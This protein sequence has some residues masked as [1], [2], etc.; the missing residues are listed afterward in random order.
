MNTTEARTMSKAEILQELVAARIS[1]GVASDSDPKRAN[2][3][4]MSCTETLGLILENLGLEDTNGLTIANVE[5][6]F[7]P[8]LEGAI[9]LYNTLVN[10]KTIDAEKDPQIYSELIHYLNVLHDNRQ[11]M[12]NI[13]RSKD[14]ITEN[15]TMQDVENVIKKFAPK[16]YDDKT[17]YQ[18]LLQYLTNQVWFLGYK[19]YQNS[20]VY[21]KRYV[22]GHDTHSYKQVSTIEQFVYNVTR[23]DFE[24]EQ[25]TLR[26]KNPGNTANSINELSKCAEFPDVD[27]DRHVFS[28]RNGLYNAKG[29]VTKD[30]K[31]YD[32]F[33]KYGQGIPEKLMAAKYFD[34]D[35]D[36][37]DDVDD[38]FDIPTPHMSSILKYQELDEDVS[39]IFFAFIGRMLY[40]VNE[41]D[42]WQVIPFLKG[43]ASS[44][45]ST[46]LNKV[47]KF[48]Y[49]DEDVGVLSNNVEKQFGLGAF[50]NK[51]IFIAPE[52][53]EDCK[54][55]QAELQSLISGE[56]IQI[57]IKG[58]TAFSVEWKVPGFL[59]ANNPLGYQ[60]NQGS[61][62]RRVVTFE[63]AKTVDEKSC[64][65]KLADNLQLEI[66]AIIVKANRAYMQLA[67]K[68]G[69][70]NIWN[71][72]PA[73]FKETRDELSQSSN[74]LENYLAVTSGKVTFGPDLYCKYETFHK[75]WKK[76]CQDLNF[77][78]PRWTREYYVPVLKKYGLKAVKAVKK[79]PPID[80][81]SLTCQW[82]VGCD[83]VN[84]GAEDVNNR[85]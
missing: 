27:K 22:N 41:L 9:Q 11:T 17:P 57:A 15:A 10:L 26:T 78:S 56:S 47:C 82:V 44:G 83:F 3:K 40:E 19:R 32:R 45:K 36:N 43:S 65:M 31:Y 67:N 69:R 4:P 77:P 52:I 39:R 74:G 48:F 84:E 72:L 18:L 12:L 6:A 54:L 61:M 53:K 13:V 70:E 14:I 16:T 51:L 30:G 76:H 34:V 75:E 29:G 81:E 7:R 55:E 63:F 68:Y 59:A 23:Q 50:Y 21:E 1:W 24:H 28:F 8:I 66:P 79:Y 35:F 38:W 49:E 46:I 42:Q 60:D 73:Y 62:S 85:M 71:G 37:F 58:K 25:W 20:L 2:N 80:G 64:D 33:Y 5:D